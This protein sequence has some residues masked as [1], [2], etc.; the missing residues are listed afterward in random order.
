M[1]AIQIY[2]ILSLYT[3]QNLSSQIDPL[4][5]VFL[6]SQP[7][8]SHVAIDS[9]AIGY[10][11]RTGMDYFAYLSDYKILISQN[12]AYLVYSN[13]I[14]GY[15]GVFIEKID[16]NTGRRLWSNFIDLRN[17]IKREQ[18]KRFFINKSGDLELLNLR[19]S[20]DTLIA[21]INDW[22]TGKLAIHRYDTLYGTE[23]YVSY[24]AIHD[25]SY[26]EFSL[27][28]KAT[29]R[30]NESDGYDCNKI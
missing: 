5:D 29:L 18:T 10:K 8:W 17:S 21:G 20:A 9:S 25:T 4:G 2:V 22:L 11:G 26:L 28:Y 1:K 14:D 27:D 30:K 15:S 13:Y 6:N 19:H 16:L 3:L 23:K 24:S 12:S 7:I